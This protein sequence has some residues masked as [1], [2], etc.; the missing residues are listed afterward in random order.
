M[1]S[2]SFLPSISIKINLSLKSLLPFTYSKN[3]LIFVIQKEL[4]LPNCFIKVEVTKGNVKDIT[5]VDPKIPNPIIRKD[6]N[7]FIIENIGE[8]QKFVSFVLCFELVYKKWNYYVADLNIIVP[9]DTLPHLKFGDYFYEE[10]VFHQPDAKYGDINLKFKAYWVRCSDSKK[11][12]VF[13]LFLEKKNGISIKGADKDN[14]VLSIP[15]KLIS[16]AKHTNKTLTFFFDFEVF[17]QLSP[18]DSSFKDCFGCQNLPGYGMDYV[19][20]YAKNYYNYLSSSKK[21]YEMPTGYYPNMINYNGM[22]PYYYPLYYS[23]PTHSC[24]TSKNATFQKNAT[25]TKSPTTNVDASIIGN[26][27]PEFVD[28][29]ES[30]RNLRIFN[31]SNASAKE[32]T[33]LGS[34]FLSF[35]E[36]THN[37][38]I[39]ADKNC[40]MLKSLPINSEF[41]APIGARKSSSKSSNE[42]FSIAGF[43]FFSE[44]HIAEVS[45]MTSKTSTEAIPTS[46]PDDLNELDLTNPTLAKLFEFHDGKLTPISPPSKP[47][48]VLKKLF[49]IISNF[50]K[51]TTKSSYAVEE[52]TTMCDDFDCKCSSFDDSFKSTSSKLQNIESPKQI[53][54]LTSDGK[55]ISDDAELLSSLSPVIKSFVAK[56]QNQKNRILFKT[57]FPLEIV[58]KVVLFADGITLHESDGAEIDIEVYKFAKL[59]EIQSLMDYC[60]EYLKEI[61]YD[62]TVKKI[63]DFA[64]KERLESLKHRCRVF[65]RDHNLELY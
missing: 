45:M 43:S 3:G 21:S 28:E 29:V 59:L 10:F 42:E 7:N 54:F 44:E 34:S 8:D 19:S 22:F 11:A 48:N 65:L 1:E 37:G 14:M 6:M 47:Q 24:S 36:E 40:Q 9:F 61:I 63:Y 4:K 60:V 64:K 27:P 57:S 30:F 41:S 5:V 23:Y 33:F 31:K 35:S 49:P 56:Q 52:D 25:A 32:K 18:S 13:K 53:V 55:E 58:E 39:S 12:S 26:V 17:P 38:Q 62:Q 46:K 50:D 16:R 20:M 15:D 51:S 2:V